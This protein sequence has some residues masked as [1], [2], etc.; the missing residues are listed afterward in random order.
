[1]SR[2]TLAQP[3]YRGEE[4]SRSLLR[5]GGHFPRSHSE[6]SH[7]LKA[8]GT[9]AGLDTKLS[10]IKTLLKLDFA[11]PTVLSMNAKDIRDLIRI[12]PFKPFRLHLADGKSLRVPHTDFIL[13]GA[14]VAVIAS[15]LPQGVPGELNLV[16]YEHIVRVE[17][18]PRRMAK[19]G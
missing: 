16:P 4:F 15:E 18:L 3:S 17:M 7:G 14:E 13:V 11:E 5:V 12:S 8:V 6:A 2:K 19:A 9:G 10:R 1:M